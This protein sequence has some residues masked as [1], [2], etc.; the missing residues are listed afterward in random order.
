M[1]PA[2]GRTEGLTTEPA[3][4]I[5]AGP[6]ARRQRTDRRFQLPRPPRRD[7]SQTAH[8]RLIGRFRA[9]RARFDPA[10]PETLNA[11]TQFLLTP[12]WVGALGLVEFGLLQIAQAWVALLSM[13]M[14][15]GLTS[16]AES[17]YARADAAVRG[18]IGLEWWRK[19]A[20]IGAGVLAAWSVAGPLLQRSLSWWTVL[21]VGLQAL[22][23]ATTPT[24]RLF[25]EERYASM[26]ASL[27]IPRLA[28]LVILLPPFRA[29]VDGVLLVGA[30]AQAITMVIVASSL[31]T[32]TAAA[33]GR[34][35]HLE[36]RQALALLVAQ[37]S[38]ITFRSGYI[39][40]IDWKFG[41]G[42]VALVAIADKAVRALQAIFNQLML[43]SIN[44]KIRTAGSGRVPIDP[45]YVVACLLGTL[46]YAAASAPLARYFLMSEPAERGSLAVLIS[47][48]GLAASV[49]SA[50]FA[51]A[52]FRLIGCGGETLF[53][54]ATLLSTAAGLLLIAL[55][56]AGL[57]ATYGAIPVLLAETILLTLVSGVVERRRVA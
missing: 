56:P 8:E 6:P 17:R 27:V 45:R 29:T 14:A 35:S 23:F 57:R 39:F 50:A 20:L 53:L 13:S 31:R 5:Y 40:L 24:W 3:S 4:G 41:R 47:L 46:V 38:G 1:A 28:P 16:L 54:R 12:V 33:R 26:T 2:G 15:A 44:R 34:A 7:V 19:V 30:C 51:V 11:G 42:V 37:A 9:L 36:L 43:A 21:L 55:M 18:E 22:L 48:F 52:R 32:F 10:I 49:G 25:I